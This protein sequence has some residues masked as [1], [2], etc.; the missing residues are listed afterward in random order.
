M[1]LSRP[2][3]KALQANNPISN[4][5][6]NQTDHA[7]VVSELFQD[8]ITHTSYEKLKGISD[9]NAELHDKVERLQTTLAVNLDY[10]NSTKAKLDKAYRDLDKAYQDLREKDK[11]VE[12]LRK[13]S[14]HFSSTTAAVTHELNESA[15]RLSRV[16]DEL[17][18][19]KAE[20]LDLTSQLEEERGKNHDK[21][22]IE[23]EL[24]ST[25]QDLEDCTV[26]L[27]RLENFSMPL[28]PT[29]ME[30]V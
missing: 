4:M 5:A 18:K 30:E 21:E 3:F 20:I 22:D 13:E 29:Q 12:N 23:Q 24:E 11:Q 14:D 8:I 15:Q 7:K 2:S 26:K 1:P 6:S 17:V 25:R 19:A 9:E 10:H 27:R 16:E 28:K